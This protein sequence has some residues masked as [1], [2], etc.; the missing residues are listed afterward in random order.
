MS[1][2]NQNQSTNNPPQ[3]PETTI[4]AL[5]TTLS[6]LRRSLPS[7]THKTSPP[8]PNPS[9]ILTTYSHLRPLLTTFRTHLLTAS[10]QKT[11]SYQ[12]LHTISESALH[13]FE[14]TKTTLIYRYGDFDFSF[15]KV[16]RMILRDMASE[17]PN[18]DNERTCADLVRTLKRDRGFA[19]E[20]AQVLEELERANGEYWRCVRV[21]DD[22]CR[23]SEQI[24]EAMAKVDERVA[25]L[26]AARAA[27]KGVV[28][29]GVGKVD[30]VKE[31]QRLKELRDQ[32][33]RLHTG[34]S[35][36]GTMRGKPDAGPFQQKAK[37][38]E[39]RYRG[40]VMG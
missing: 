32:L 18:G 12:H 37:G 30:V 16:Y 22:L 10:R 40:V 33:P 19:G 27:A 11:T 39:R 25:P 36:A 2:E 7:S 29:P 34:T 15:P 28:L 24:D 23:V 6:T 17:M 13:A 38:K 9:S 3:S 8:A 1:Q 14:A 4:R 26:I 31:S 5:T 35:H 21:F 20:N